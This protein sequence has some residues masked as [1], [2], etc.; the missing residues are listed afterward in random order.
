MNAKYQNQRYA[1]AR[2]AFRNEVEEA[3][4]GP[5][6]GVF[7]SSGDEEYISPSYT[8]MPGTYTEN[9]QVGSPHGEEILSHAINRAVQRFENKET[10]KLIKTE[11]DFVT[12]GKEELDNSA[13]DDDDYELIDHVHAQ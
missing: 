6:A 10:E 5:L 4:D 7:D 9:L 1:V 8:M 3:T 12:D 11:Y 2:K 13:T